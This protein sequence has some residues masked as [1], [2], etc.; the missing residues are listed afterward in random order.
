MTATR[1]P[2][3]RLF[4]DPDLARFYDLENGWAADF[5]A[6]ARLACDAGSVLDL[7]CG[8]GELAA[9]LAE[10]REVVG[11]GPAAA[12]L[13]IAR[14]RPGGERVIWVQATAQSLRLARTFDLVVLT[15]HAFQVFLSDA[16]QQAVLETIARH[17][18][19]D[20]R[21][22]FDSRN[23]AAAAWR[24]WTPA[25]SRRRLTH[26]QLGEVEAWTDAAHDPDSGIVTYRTRYRVVGDERTFSATSR[27]RFTPREDLATRIAAAGLAVERWLGD[28][29]G[30][31]C[32]AAAPDI[33][34]LGRLAETGSARIGV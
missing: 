24:D 11:A 18:A 3:D 10:G 17:L 31:D 8:T 25:R 19:P 34:P 14:R 28:W 20:G 33:I 16:D 13:E 23:P 26:P 5:E 12:M 7:G 6:C 29:A 27:I 21:F 2:D 22:I 1:L 4:Q 32:T 9:H 30:A 15:G